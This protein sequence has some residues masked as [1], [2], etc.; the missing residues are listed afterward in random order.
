[1]S[2]P[3][4][5]FVLRPFSPLMQ[6]VWDLAIRPAVLEAGLEAWDGQEE[7]LGT[8]VIHNDISHLIWTSRLVIADLTGRNPNVMY[9][10]GLSHAAKKPTI[11]LIEEEEVPPFD[12]T[13]IRFLK[14][15]KNRLKSL[16]RALVDRIRSTLDPQNA[17]R[18]EDHFPEL[19]VLTDEIRRELEYLRARSHRLLI[20]ITPACADV[21]VNDKL[22]GTGNQQV[23]VNPEFGRNT[24]S[25]STVGFLEHHAE[26]SS[27]DLAAGRVE[28][29]LEKFHVDGEQDAFR[30]SRRVPRWLRDRRRDPQ[31]P[32]LMRAISSYLLTTGEEK[33]AF[34]EIEDLLAVAPNWYM[35]VNQLGF[36]YGLTGRL[37]DA[38]VHYRRVS[39]LKPD[40]FIG[41]FNQSCALALLGELDA[42]LEILD[43][44]VRNDGA[45]SSIRE[46]LQELSHDPDFDALIAD[47]MR[48][49]RFRDIELELFPGSRESDWQNR[50][51]RT[52]YTF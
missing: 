14:Y 48:S 23:L 26:I 15:S 9:E 22:L 32:V 4:R 27:D 46:T 52:Y 43:E 38:M 36:Y 50:S 16:Q 37:E 30:L 34:D 11:L 45:R 1:M 25:A 47:D 17:P 35:S 12:I 44:I 20:D 13:H 18:Q 19:G 42:S 10:L 33:D 7:K 21:F 49:T 5:C 8:N 51:G 2:A 6:N 40:H 29:R 28:V 3:E 39:A 24:I 41:Y 31:N